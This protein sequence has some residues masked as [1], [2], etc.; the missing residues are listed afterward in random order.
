MFRTAAALPLLSLALFA[1]GCATTPRPSPVDVTRYHLG[2]PLAERSSVTMEPMASSGAEIVAGDFGAAS[3]AVAAQLRALGFAPVPTGT[4]TTG[5]VASISY[6]RT[7][8]GKVATPPP[9]TIGLGGGS[10]SGGYRGGVGVGA[11]GSFGI[12]GGYRDVIVSTLAV[13]LRRRSDN[14]VVWDGK[15]Q[16][17]WVEGKTPTPQA[18]TVNRLAQALFKDFPGESGVTISVK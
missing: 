11:S 9:V 16:T 10:F 4:A 13:Q 18:Q 5:Y 7:L 8:S 17:Q 2:T 6:T 15:A 3:D 1:G 12:G 14:S